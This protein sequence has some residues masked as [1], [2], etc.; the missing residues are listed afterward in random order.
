MLYPDNAGNDEFDTETVENKVCNCSSFY[1]IAT[2]TVTVR[3]TVL[4]YFTTA[5]AL[6]I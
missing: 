3:W 4:H 2:D 5:E 1:L 6:K